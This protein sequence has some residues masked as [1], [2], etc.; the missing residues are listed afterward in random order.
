VIFLSAV[1][2]F[3]CAI[4]QKIPFDYVPSAG[5]G[6]ASRPLTLFEVEDNRPFVVNR[7]K[8][9]DW[10]GLLRGGYGNPFDVGTSSHQPFAHEVHQALA[11]ELGAL[12]FDVYSSSVLSGSDE[13]AL[14]RAMHPDGGR[15]LAVVIRWWKTNTYVNT[16]IDYSFLVRVIDA[17]G[18]SLAEQIVERHDELRGSFWNPPRAMKKQVAAAYDDAIRRIVRDNPVILSALSATDGEGAGFQQRR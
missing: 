2:T 6:H 16:D 12:G 18:R 10:V 7:D 15:G 5:P 13:H 8:A 14:A 4:G 1:V 11:R 17:S 3:G 9:A